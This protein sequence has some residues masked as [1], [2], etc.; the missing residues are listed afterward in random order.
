VMKRRRAAISVHSLSL[1]A[2]EAVIL[3]A[4]F[5]AGWNTYKPLI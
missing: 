5:H 2:R 1:L 4:A 3:K